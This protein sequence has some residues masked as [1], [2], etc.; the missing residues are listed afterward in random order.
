MTKKRIRFK[1]LGGIRNARSQDGVRRD[2]SPFIKH[3]RLPPM[4]DTFAAAEA[5][6]ACRR[7]RTP[8][9]P[10]AGDN[11]PQPEAARY[12]IAGA[13]PRLLSR[14][15]GE[16]VGHKIGCTSA[17]MQQYLNIPH[18]CSGGVVANGVQSSRMALS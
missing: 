6:A 10:F 5:I 13:V 8:L 3:R 15:F 7:N 17:V 11:A 2:A 1:S 4:N 14:D 9:H 16:M 18:P 12:R